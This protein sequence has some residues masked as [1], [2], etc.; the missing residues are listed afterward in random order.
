MT[1][2]AGVTSTIPK[3]LQILLQGTDLSRFESYTNSIGTQTISHAF[4]C[5]GAM[6]EEIFVISSDKAIKN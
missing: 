4:A 2:Q 6:A 5:F 3:D 1:K